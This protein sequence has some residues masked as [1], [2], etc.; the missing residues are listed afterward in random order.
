MSSIPASLWLAVGVISTACVSAL[1]ISI[2]RAYDHKTKRQTESGPDPSPLHF[3]RKRDSSVPFSDV[4]RVP[5]LCFETA[6]I[7]AI[8]IYNLYLCV[9]ALSDSNGSQQLYDVLGAAFVLAAWVYALALALTSQ[10]YRLPN[11]WGFVINV[12]LCI[13]YFVSWC[14]CGWALYDTWRANPTWSNGM[15]KLVCFLFTC[16]LLYVTATIKRGAPFLDEND[17]IVSSVNV[18]SAFG[19]LFFTWIRPL[20]KHAYKVRKLNDNDLPTLPPIYR[21]YNLFYIFGESRGHNLLRRIWDANRVAIILQVVLALISSVLYYVPHFYTNRLLKLIQD[22]GEGHRTENGV[23]EGF[24]I[25]IQQGISFVL[26]GLNIG[27]LWYW[28]ASSLQVRLKAMLN[29]EIYHKTL[30]RLDSAIASGGQEKE[31]SGK[32]TSEED[33]TKSEEEDE[34]VTSTGQIVNLMSTDSDRISEFSTWWFNAITCP[35]ELVVGTYFLYTILGVSCFTGLGVMVLALPLNHY[36]A[37][38]FA[39]TQDRLMDARDK[40]VSLMNEVLQGIRQIKFFAS[41]SNWE[42]RIMQSRAVEL[43]YLRTAYISEALFQMVWQGLPILVTAIAFWSYTMLEGNELTAS[44]AFTS[45]I[46]FDELRF[47]LIALPDIFID[48]L[49]AWTSVRRI[50]KYLGQEEIEAPAPMNADEPVKIGFD[51]ATVAWT[52]SPNNNE[53]SQSSSSSQDTCAGPDGFILKDV[54]LHFPNDKLSLICGKTGSGKSLLL[55][56]L[57]GEA[58]VTKGKVHCPRAPIATTVSA[59]FHVLE[60]IPEE[61]WI[62]EHSLAFVAQTAWLQNASI[63]DNILFGLPYV[64]KRYQATLSACALDKDLSIFEDGDMTEIG[65][66]GITLSGGQKA[67]VALARAVYSRAKI[68]LMDDVLS[69]VD[70]HTAKHLYRNCLMGPLMKGRTR[71]LVTH[72][73]KL[74]LGGSDY[75][76]HVDAGRTDI[77]GAPTELRQSGALASILDEDKEDEDDVIED[78]V[79]EVDPQPVATT[80][81]TNKKPPKALIEEEHRETG[82]IKMRL[83]SLYFKAGGSWLF[84]I[85]V[86]FL[87][88]GN[89]TLEIGESWWIKQWTST[90]ND[91]NTTNMFSAA[92]I[93]HDTSERSLPNYTPMIHHSDDDFVQVSGLK[94]HSVMY[95]LGIYVLITFSGVLATT[96]RFIAVFVGG[97]RASRKMYDDLLRRVFRA[98]LRF[99]DTT[100]IGRILNRFSRDFETIDSQVPHNMMSFVHTAITVVSTVILVGFAIPVFTIPMLTIIVLYIAVGAMFVVTSRELKR[101]DSVS[102]SPLF[103]HFSE[104]IVGVATIRAFGVTRQFMQ[105]MLKRVDTNARPY[106]YVWTANRWVS[107]QFF[108]LGAVISIGTGTAILLNLDYLDAA[109]AGF[110]LT[111]VLA[112]HN[113][114]FWCIRRYTSVEMNFN[115]VERVAEFMEMDQEAPAVTD[116]RPPSLWPSEGR[117]QV[118]DLEVRYAP[119]LDPVLKGISFN[120]NPREKVGVVGRTGSGKSTLALSFFRFVE[121]SRGSIVI[122]GI[123]IKDIGTEDLRGN[124][125]IIPQDPTLFSGTL[126]TNMDPFN[127]FSDDDIFT[128]LRRVHLLPSADSLE[129]DELEEVN[130]NVF[131]DLET[132]VSEGGKNFSQ[133]QRQLLCLARALLRRSHLVLMDE[134]TASVDFQTDKA[135]QKTITTE[136]ADCSILCIAHRLHTVIE[137]DRILVLDQGKIVEYASPLELISNSE[138]VFH[139]MCR[140][141]GEFDSLMAL[142]KNKHQLVDV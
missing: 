24:M 79:E 60:D 136:F 78:E 62:L 39:K 120:V 124:L 72:H 137:Y 18:S 4:D 141:S 109:A 11:D 50:E 66:K 28:A 68:I 74:C 80:T 107:L 70:A 86:L 98:P 19:F 81:E 119:D 43:G 105:E 29:I 35:A 95:Y 48:G 88:I 49:Q 55:L 117:V 25:V 16:D 110:C 112:L 59:T 73:V 101:M 53:E 37:Q 77:A 93:M 129:A 32:K 126:R 3:D 69:A 6:I 142:A 103:S 96:L 100:P 36:N 65:E 63:R 1:T 104:T 54:N 121:A 17:H 51:N 14:Y 133:G 132:S 85:L 114:M 128:A 67:R 64:E 61:E 13:V 15:P 8:S 125:T 46:V 42:K 92:S 84:W 47:S 58:M 83:Y 113:N 56:G 2:Q 138:S 22:M 40:R 94:G 26:L 89:R 76:V 34:D 30:R 10:R 102:R 41:E 123:D 90:E 5:R 116:V 106:Y 91:S 118:E 75:L 21:G 38:L 20:V 127:Q 139:Q 99:F 12:H 130:A 44:V 134:A 7:T 27:Q 87:V 45:I 33:D 108:L 9:Q 57:L 31:E 131:R 71:V 82:K 122:D 97:L 135:I 52:A 140:K 111:F 23:E 115:S